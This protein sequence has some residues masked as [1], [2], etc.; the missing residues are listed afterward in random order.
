MTGGARRERR[1]DKRVRKREKEERRETL[2]TGYWRKE[3]EEE[4]VTNGGRK[5]KDS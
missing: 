1:E 5:R 2:F 3:S 4:C